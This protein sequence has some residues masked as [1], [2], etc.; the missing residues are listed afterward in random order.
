MRVLLELMVR[1]LRG[2]LI[3]GVKLLK[4]PR[5]LAGFLV[6]FAYFA[7]LLARPFS[8]GIRIGNR[9]DF[10]VLEAAP[11]LTLGVAAL[12]AI[13]VALSWLVLPGRPPITL[14]RAEIHLLFPAPLSRRTLLLYGL[15]KT[16]PIS[17]LAATVIAIFTGLGPV[18]ILP[19][20]CGITAWDLQGRLR[21]QWTAAPEAWVRTGSRLLALVLLG[22]VLVGMGDVGFNAYGTLSAD[23][24]EWSESG[25]VEELSERAG[26]AWVRYPLTPFRWVTGAFFTESMPELPRALGPSLVVVLLLMLA[27]MR[28]QV[29]F[30]DAVVARERHRAT[31]VATQR[32]GWLRQRTRSAH[33]FP[34]APTGS[35][36]IAVIWR[37]ATGRLRLGPRTL[38]AAW[39]G[40]LAATAL[41]NALT[42]AREAAILTQGIVALQAAALSMVASGAAAQRIVLDL[43][44]I[45]VVRTW[46]IP[47]RR[48][49]WAWAASGG[50]SGI[51]LALAVAAFLLGLELGIR[52]AAVSGAH[53][54]A[55]VP[56]GM[57]AFLGASPL[58]VL[59][60]LIVS[61]IVLLSGLCVLTATIQTLITL[62]FPGWALLVADTQ[63]GAGAMGQRILFTVAMLFVVVVTLLPAAILVGALILLHS[64]T[65]IPVSLWEVP[66]AAVVLLVPLGLVIAAL[67]RIAGGVWTRLDPSSEILTS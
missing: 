13:L 58:A 7:W 32:R 49:V 6:G 16:Q 31:R 9:S 53:T 21:G 23:G 25:I 2:R 66:A 52:A 47:P 42:G 8:S 62:L 14:S 20:W 38:I 48:L 33:P 35:P 51:T 26:Q 27:V 4:Q 18:A 1:R 29:R 45:D 19:F 34:L 15:L 22:V 59:L 57:A 64:L 5:Y 28:S 36:E 44:Q 46:P 30:E 50:L 54:T 37:H 24:V 63:R 65:G 17:L 61:G 11:A 60:V 41:V 12:V 40:I 56:D 3:R 43:R 67:V 39:F 10:P 55:L